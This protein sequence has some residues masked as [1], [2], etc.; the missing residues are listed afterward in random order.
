MND[1][2]NRIGIDPIMD[3]YLMGNESF[4]DAARMN[5]QMIID[6]ANYLKQIAAKDD[7]K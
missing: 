1:F 5:T 6:D 3:S 2:R 7:Y 4:E